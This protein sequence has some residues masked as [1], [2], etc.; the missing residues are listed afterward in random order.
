MINTENGKCRAWVMSLGLT[1]PSIG[2]RGHGRLV[3]ASRCSCCGTAVVATFTFSVAEIIHG[4][5]GSV[6]MVVFLFIGVSAVAH[7]ADEPRCATR[8]LPGPVF[9]EVVLAGLDVA[10]RD[11]DDEADK[12]VEDGVDEN[13][14]YED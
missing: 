8:T 9:L 10:A 3:F 11:E 6:L 2:R 13:T 5:L 14:T 4:V 12:A 1:P 7:G